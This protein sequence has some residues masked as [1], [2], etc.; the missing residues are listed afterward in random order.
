V[1]LTGADLG[2]VAAD[3][4][5]YAGSHKFYCTKGDNVSRMEVGH[6]DDG[7]G[8]VAFPTTQVASQ[9]KAGVSG[10]YVASRGNV[11]SAILLYT[12]S[13]TSLQKCAEFQSSGVLQLFYGFGLKVATASSASYAV[14][15]GDAVILCDTT[16]TAIAVNLPT[17]S[18]RLG[19]V[20]MVK[21]LI[22]GSNNVTINRAGTDTIDGGT[23][24]TLSTQYSGYVLAAGAL[25]GGTT[26]GWHI[27][28]KYL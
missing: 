17:A 19:R 7:V 18:T 5:N 13:G 3:A 20:L 25:A 28:S 2:A 14:S 11:A 8:G 24:L 23:S 16:S 4:G 22:G 1:A 21:K 15:D 10:L 9:V 12:G 26:Y 27:I 6:F